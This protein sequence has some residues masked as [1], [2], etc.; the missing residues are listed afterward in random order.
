MFFCPPGLCVLHC[1]LYMIYLCITC[2]LLS[3]RIVCFALFPLYDI[4]LHHL[5][6]SVHPDCVFCI[7][8]SIWYTFASLVFFCPPGL[9][10]LHCS[11]YMIYL[12]ITCVVLSTRIVYFALFPLF[13]IPLH[14]L[15]FSVHP[16]CVFCIVPSIWYTFASLVFFCPPRL[17]VLHCSLYMIYLCITCVLLSTRIVCFALFPLYDIPL[18][19]LC[20]SVHPIVCF[21][22]FPLYDIPLH[23]LCFSVHPDCV[24]CIVPSIWHTFASLVFFCP[25]GLCVLRCFLYMIYLCITCVVLST[26]IVCFALFPLYDIPLH[27]LCF[28]VHPDCV[29]CIVP[30]I[31]YTFASLVFFCQP[32]LCVL[33]CSLYM[34]YL[35]ITC[36][37]LSTRMVC[38]S[39]F[40]LYDIPLHHLC[41]SVHLD[42]VFC[43]VPSIWYTFA[44]LVFFC[45]PGLCV[46]HCFLYMIYLCITCVFLSTRIV[47]F[48]L[49]P[50]YDIPLHHLCFSVHPDGVFFI[51]PSIWYT[52]ASL[53]FFCPLGLCVLHCSVYM[54]YFCITCVFLSTRF[55]CF[56]LFPLYDIPLHHLCFSVHPYCVFCIVPSIWYTF[57]SLVFFCPPGLCV[58]HCFR[59]MIY[60]CIT[61]VFL[62]TQ[63]V[64]FAL[65]PLYDITLHHLC[66][67]VHPDGV[68]FI[69]PSIW[70][71]F[72]SL[73]FF[74]PPGLCVLHCSL[75]MI[76]LCITCFLLSTWIVCF[77]LFPLYDIPLHQLC[78]SV[79]PDCVFCIVPSI[80]YTFASLVFFCPPIL[81]VLHCFLY[82]I[83]LCITCVFL[84]TRF[85]CFALFPLYDIPLHHLCSSVHPVG[86]FCIVSSI[87][88]T[89]ASL[90][91]FC[92]PGLCVLH[93]SLYMIYL[94]I[95]CVLLSTRIVCFALFPLYDIPL[96][97]LCSSVHPDCV[98]CIVPSIWYTFAS[99]VFLCPPGLC[100]LHC[101]LYMIYLCITCV[102]LS[103]RIVCFALFPLYDIPLH[104]LCFSVHPVCVFCIVPSIWYTFASLVFFCPPGLCVL[105]CSLYMIY[106][107]ITCVFLSTRFVCFALFPLYD[108]PLHHLCFSVHPDCVFCTVPSIW[109]T[110]ASLVL[111]CPPGLCVLHCS[112]YM[113]YLC[114]TCV[115]L[116]TRFVCF[117]LFPLYDIPLHHLCSSVHLDCVFCIVP[118][119]WYTFASLVFFCPP[120][121]C[122]LHCSL[123]MIYL[124]ITCVFLSTQIVCFALFPLYDI[125]LHHLCFSVHPDCVFCIVPS[126]WYTFA[127]LVFFCPPRLCVLHCSLYMIFLCITCVF[128]STQI[129]C[130]ALF[131]LYDIPLHHLC[132]SVHPDCVFCIVPSIWY[133]FASL[134]FF[135][136]PGLCVLHCSLYMIYLCITCVLLST[137]I[138]CFALFPLY[139]IPLHHSCSS[140]HLDC[141]FCIVPSIWYT[142]AS[143]V[144]FC[145]PGLCVLHC[146]L[147]MIYLC[148]TC[149]LL[150]TQIVCFAL[151][152][153]YDIP[154]HHS[155]SSVHPDCVFCI[156]P[157]IWYTFASLV[158]FCPPGLCVLHCSLYMIYLCITCVLLSTRIVC[159]ALFPIYDI[160]LHHLCSSVHPDCVF[161]IVPSIWYT[162]ASLVFF[163][164]PG[165]CVL[166]CS[167]YMIY[168]CITCVLLSTQI[169]CF[170]L[171]P[172]YDIPLHH[173]CSSV[174]PDCVFCI[175][176]SI[177]YTFASLVFFCPPGLCVLHC[178][179]YMIYLCI[180]CVLLFICIVFLQYS[181]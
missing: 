92:P 164:P 131:P 39:L 99:L 112:L 97:H 140:V 179:L 168:L 32:G 44:S 73:V 107:C 40:P 4:P 174:H 165:L 138:V 28:S 69:V 110:F 127:S 151:F 91:F 136:P 167:L 51:V 152:P 111:F 10:V 83:Y 159:F 29:F 115:F 52:F 54:I 13:D 100:V 46:L 85:V 116:S 137:W 117:A 58:F 76:Y 41:S 109:Y 98:F 176:P 103:T 56:A 24:F 178:S 180:T 37:F 68:F 36:V 25:P 177:W 163:C 146:S 172:L 169:V 150:F 5:C 1:S 65:F 79:H 162:F 142:F 120:G 77:A 23:H 19:H 126:I 113:I 106:L 35:C 141:V 15:C 72:A 66:F 135:C 95:T 170:A 133:T 12:C 62:S 145:P 128:L 149:V 143:L 34:I 42:C 108:I 27:H 74:C 96:H 123:Y 9:C 53:V 61:C 67:S 129:V 81:C 93:C 102:L 30:S 134:V 173:S 124:C 118:S 57:A 105:H 155:C 2:V 175:V 119:I 130:F 59:Y 8:S 94:C 71:T 38:F 49:F 48:A 144:F 157:S 14:H 80:W 139:D 132:S 50:L 147:Y 60:L 64:C 125:P 158:F 171:F 101:F 122:V 47:C 181:P 148:I 17:C 121:L 22:F 78:S 86:V 31:W 153:L 43:I 3:T 7:V 11:L 21:A 87:W 26:R 161:C 114:I 84:S 70:Y 88:Y 45:P 156:V 90:V 6:F 18:H 166:H 75:Y 16:D 160:P 33:H 63:I 55:V 154:L 104:H 82:M 20:S 89:F